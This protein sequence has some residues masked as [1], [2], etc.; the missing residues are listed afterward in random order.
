MAFNKIN[1]F[2]RMI[3]VENTLFGLPFAYLGAFLAARGW[4][5]IHTFFWITV[6]MASAR[7]AAMCLN[8]LIDRRFDR[9]NPRTSH[10]VMAREELSVPLIWGVAILLSGILMY[11]AA[12]LNPLCL[13]LSPLAVLILWGYS[14]TKRF[15]W[16]CHLILGAAIGIGPVG[17][18]FAV[19]GTFD[20]QPFL[21]AAVVAT[22][23]G[24]F[25][26]LY[27]CQDV[28]FDRKMGLYSIPARFGIRKAFGMIHLLHFATI[29]FLILTGPVFHLGWKYYIGVLITAA[30]LLYEHSIVKP[31]QLDQIGRAAFQLN[32]YVSSILFLCTCWDLWF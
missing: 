9:A 23:V 11:A 4:P 32:H 1:K 3:D 16:L 26:A 31:S 19:T 21:L 27:A 2:L 15:T 22:W 29:L 8:R 30:I 28:E 18:W 13:K 12:Q 7:T 6:A 25:D 10:W 24:G 5:G 17:G 20:W 14:Y